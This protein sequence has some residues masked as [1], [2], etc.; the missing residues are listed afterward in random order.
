M[1]ISGAG[2]GGN[3]GSCFPRDRL[4]AD[5]LLPK[6]AASSKWAQVNPAGQG[7]IM[8]VNLL[9]A[10]ALV[11]S[12]STQGALRNASLDLRSAPPNPTQ[13]VS[14]WLN[15]TIVPLINRPLEIGGEL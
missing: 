6:D 12:N 1:P 5:N 3:A 9:S 10:G 11:G 2:F 13:P 8:N 14:P 4:S 7:D 15:S